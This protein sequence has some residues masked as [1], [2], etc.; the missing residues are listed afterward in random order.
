MIKFADFWF[1]SWYKLTMG[2]LKN[3][4]LLWWYL[5]FAALLMHREWCNLQELYRTFVQYNL[6][7]QQL[8]MVDG[9][10]CSCLFRWVGGLGYH[11]NLAAIFLMTIWRGLCWR[12]LSTL[13]IRLGWNGTW[14]HKTTTIGRPS[15]LTYV[16]MWHCWCPESLWTMPSSMI[17]ALVAPGCTILISRYLRLDRADLALFVSLACSQMVPFRWD[18]AMLK[19]RGCR[20]WLCQHRCTLIS[21]DLT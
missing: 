15:Q 2:Y 5:H 21:L 13:I 18:S 4:R 8:H 6:V 1:A 19:T 14:I 20:R 11:Y 17:D 3:H 12:K 9:W 16:R 7:P 10:I